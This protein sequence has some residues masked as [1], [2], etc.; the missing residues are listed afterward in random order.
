MN[1]SSPFIRRPIGT[2]LLAVA[3][4]L[5]GA[6]AFV[7]LPIAP[8][9]RVE[10]PTISVSAGLPGASPT[11]MATAIAMPLERRFGR[12][13][14]VTEITSESTLGRTD[15]TIQFDLDKDVETAAREIQAAIQAAGGDLPPNMPSRPSYR[16]V[17]P[18]GAPI[19]IIA[20]RSKSLELAEIYEAANT[21][22]AQKIAQVPGVGQVGVGGGI[23]RAVRVSVDP[24]LLA[25]MG[26]GLEEVRTAIQSATANQPKG[27][28]GAEQWHAISVDDQLIGAA[29]WR[30]LIVRWATPSADRTQRAPATAAHGGAVRLGD[31]ATVTDDVENDRVAGWF[32]AERSISVMVRRQPGANI[33]EVI[34]RVKTLL[35]ELA[36]TIHPRS[37]S[38]SRSIAPR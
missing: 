27:G 6:A 36:R 1:I 35:P 23:Q 25:G 13:A 18:S 21:V 34:D 2:T 29:A 4:L 37:T 38:T 10:I 24:Q 12:I 14:G 20:L 22:L 30:Q 3:L 9:P 32:D 16:K 33:L 11:T 26:I 7:S 15:I 5:A 28:V 8:L 17:D 19:L 31:I